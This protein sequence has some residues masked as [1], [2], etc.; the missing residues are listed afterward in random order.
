MPVVIRS[1]G[2]KWR[3]VARSGID[4]RNRLQQRGQHFCTVY[5]ISHTKYP[6][7]V[8]FGFS[9]E[10]PLSSIMKAKTWYK[11]F[12]TVCTGIKLLTV[13]CV[14]KQWKAH[15]LLTLHNVLE[16]SPF[17]KLIAAHLIK[18]FPTFH[19]PHRIVSVFRKARKGGTCM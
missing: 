12:M 4:H 5:Q 9:S 18:K 1:D 2:S 3:P 11:V 10:S 17:E 15:R 14:N 19:G 13:I 8:L 16:Q 7:V 6:F